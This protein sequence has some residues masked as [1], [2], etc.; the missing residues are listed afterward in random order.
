MNITSFGLPT[1]I[2]PKAGEEQSVPALRFQSWND[3]EKYFLDL[4]ADPRELETVAATLSRTG[5]AV[6]TSA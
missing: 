3:A 1:M 5:V 4:G 6:L 2:Y